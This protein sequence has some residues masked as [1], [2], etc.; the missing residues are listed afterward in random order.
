MKNLQ[1]RFEQIQMIRAG[2][3][4]EILETL[5]FDVD[6]SVLRETPPNK[7][8]SKKDLKTLM[9]IQRE[10]LANLRHD[11]MMEKRNV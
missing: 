3:P 5:D 4:C 8:I 10:H 2:T 11:L 9:I 1:E 7:L 6:F